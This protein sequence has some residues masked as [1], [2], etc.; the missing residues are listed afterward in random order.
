MTKKKHA[1][2]YVPR[3]LPRPKKLTVATGLM[4]VFST[5]ILALA[6]MDDIRLAGGYDF[7][8]KTPGT[9]AL[10]TILGAAAMS[11]AFKM[12]GLSRDRPK[13]LVVTLA[14]I[15]TGLAIHV[16]IM[17]ASHPGMFGFMIVM[18]AL[19]AVALFL[20]GTARVQD[21]LRRFGWDALVNQK[22]P[23]H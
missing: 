23:S 21:D 13:I 3:P 12:I 15:V 8:A 7:L 17:F 1:V 19:T 6:L 9:H 10:R 11:V 16:P 5:G 4:C 20:A 2:K 14:V 22:P 18:V